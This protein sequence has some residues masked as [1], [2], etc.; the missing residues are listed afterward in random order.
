MVGPLAAVAQAVMGHAAG[1]RQAWGNVRGGTSDRCMEEQVAS[2]STPPL[3]APCCFP[4]TTD[5]YCSRALPVSLATAFTTA[6][7]RR[8]R[9]KTALS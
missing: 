1:G 6:V 9:F 3:P 4:R 2:C 7:V 8:D 5:P